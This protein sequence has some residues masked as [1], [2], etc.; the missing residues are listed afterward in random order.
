MDPIQSPQSQRPIQPD[1]LLSAPR[2][3]AVWLKLIMPIAIVVAGALVAGAIYITES[4]PAAP[5]TLANALNTQPQI[6]VK[7]INAQDHILGDANAKVALIVYSDLECPF[8]KGFDG[9]LN[10]LHQA[11]ASDTLAIVYRHFPLDIHPRARKEAEASE[12]ATEQGGNA[13]FW[14]YITEVFAETPSNNGLDPA[15]LPVI[16]GKV[17]LDVTAFNTCLS[18]GKYTAAIAADYDAGVAAGAAGTPYSVLLVKG[19]AVPFVDG[20]GNGLG[21]LPYASMKTIIDAF[22]KQS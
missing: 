3:Q 2:P 10:Q 8:C 7:P 17:G 16:A 6:T 19:Q 20:Q 12:C 22:L 14:A 21:A 18:S 15:L 13:G 5:N 4:K 9:T 1:H 11:Y